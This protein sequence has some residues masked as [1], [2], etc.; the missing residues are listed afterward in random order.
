MHMFVFTPT[1]RCVYSDT[2]RTDMYDDMDLVEPNPEKQG[3]LKPPPLPQQ[4][5]PP[6]LPAGVPRAPYSFSVTVRCNF[7]RNSHVTAI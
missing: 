3:S 2:R 7:A 1:I 5:Q 4:N 6:P